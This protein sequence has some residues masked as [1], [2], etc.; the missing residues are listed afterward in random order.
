VVV[1]TSKSAKL[2]ECWCTT[3]NR[4]PS[5]ERQKPRGVCPPVGAK[6]VGTE[7]STPPSAVSANT[8]MQS[9]PRLDAY[10]NLPE[11]A[12]QT[13]GST[14][15]HH[16]RQHRF[17]CA[18]GARGGE[19]SLAAPGLCKFVN[20]TCRPALAREPTRTCIVLNGQCGHGLLQSQRNNARWGLIQP[21][22]LR[23]RS[24]NARPCE[25]V[26]LLALEGKGREGKGR[27]G[28]GGGGRAEDTQ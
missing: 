23:M 8:A 7:T 22:S 20:P 26:D 2:R 9:K 28:K 4:A 1:S 3:A 17:Q 16:T 13:S 10:T 15:A 21:Y 25:R 12:H 19:G 18:A 6:M 5:A 11:G 14:Q 27:E 24:S